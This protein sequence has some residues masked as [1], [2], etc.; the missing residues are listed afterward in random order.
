MAVS[1]N[2]VLIARLHELVAALDRRSPRPERT[3]EH[4]IARD[5]AELR[6]R[7]VAQIAHLEEANEL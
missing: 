6:S 3:S 7:A 2:S 1:Q 5:S 4:Q